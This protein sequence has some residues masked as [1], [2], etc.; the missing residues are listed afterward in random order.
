MIWTG[1]DHQPHIAVPGTLIQGLGCFEGGKI[2]PGSLAMLRFW[3][4]AIGSVH[5]LQTTAQKPGLVILAI[6]TPGTAQNEQF[7]LICGMSYSVQRFKARRHLL[8]W[9][10]LMMECPHGPWLVGQVAL[11]HSQIGGTEN[12]LSRAGVR[13]GKH[14]HRGDTR[15]R[16]HGLHADFRQQCRIIIPLTAAN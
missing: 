1:L 8:I 2:H 5:N 7:N 15:K 16:A 12:A 6:R 4:V 9:I 14:R 3:F 10:E 11:G 13:L